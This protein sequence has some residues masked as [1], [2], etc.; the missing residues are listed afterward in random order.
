MAQVCEA[1]SNHR[2]KEFLEQGD[3]FPSPQLNYTLSQKTEECSGNTKDTNKCEN[4][5]EQLEQHCRDLKSQLDKVKVEIVKILSERNACSKENCALKNHI[6]DLKSSLGHSSSLEETDNYYRVAFLSESPSLGTE[7]FPASGEPSLELKSG[8]SEDCLVIS[9]T[10]GINVNEVR[11]VN[12]DESESIF[13]LKCEFADQLSVV[14]ENHMKEKIELLER[15]TNLES[16]IEM[17]RQEYEKCEDYWASKLEEERVNYDKEQ[18]T[19]DKKYKKILAE[20]KEYDE[21]LNEDRP[22]TCRR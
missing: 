19:L 15:C 12:N 3:F 16:S 14:E 1:E 4:T 13:L 21:Y 5:K 9:E 18:R 17:L 10:N 8:L 2:L 20:L 22:C 6:S 11:T 7:N